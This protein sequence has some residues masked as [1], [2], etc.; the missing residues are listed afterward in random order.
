MLVVENLAA[1]YGSVPVLNGVSLQVGRGEVLT[2]LGRNGV[3]KTTLMRCL[4]G[5]MRSLSGRV[6]LDGVDLTGSAAHVAARRGLALVPQGRGILARLSVAENIRLGSR[7]AGSHGAMALDELL[8]LFPP[9]RDRLRR[10]AGTLSG[11][12]QQQLAIARALASRPSVLLLDEPSEGIQPNAVLLVEQNIDFALRTA[13]RCA[14]M[15][16]GR[17]VHEGGPDELR[18]DAVLKKFLAI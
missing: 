8:Q 16:K 6:A 12:Q 18:D 13:S 2:L 17:I 5:L 9:L 10:K 15:E 7:A 3:G 1:A 11:G 14:I 4:T